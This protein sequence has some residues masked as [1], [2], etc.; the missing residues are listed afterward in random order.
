MR[1]T[2]DLPFFQPSGI[3]AYV[4]VNSRQRAFNLLYAWRQSVHQAKR[5]ERVGV[6]LQP[7]P[8]GIRIAAWLKKKV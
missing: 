7:D 4:R 3:T 6:R 5:I 8:R 2:R 1:Y